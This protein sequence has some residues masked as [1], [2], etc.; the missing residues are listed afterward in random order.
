MAEDEVIGNLKEW[1][2]SSSKDDEDNTGGMNPILPVVLGHLF[3]AKGK[4]WA[5]YNKAPEK[6]IHLLERM[7]HCLRRVVE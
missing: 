3:S 5:G 2:S 4:P 6:K 7:G 1:G